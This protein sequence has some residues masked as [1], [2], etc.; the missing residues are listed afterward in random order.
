M[1]FSFCLRNSVK[2]PISFKPALLTRFFIGLFFLLS[3]FLLSAQKPAGTLHLKN[4]D[5]I[6]QENIS[7]E[8]VRNEIKKGWWKKEGYFILV[9]NTVPSASQLNRLAANGIK[10]HH[11]LPDYAYQVSCNFFPSA[12]VLKDAGVKSVV[13]LP[14]EYKFGKEL[15]LFLKQPLPPASTIKV[16]LQ[17][18][19]NVNTAEALT[20]LRQNGFFLTSDQFMN[21]GLLIGT[22]SKNKISEVASLP[23]VNYI[24][25]ANFN[26]QQLNHRERGVYGLTA[27]SSNHGVSRQ[28]N[29][30]GV[31]AG[32][33]D[34]ADPSSHLD[35]TTNAVNRNPSLISSSTHGTIVSSVVSGDGIIQERLTGV[36]PGSFLISD[37]FDFIVTK[38]LT[39]VTDYGLTVTNNSYFNGLNGCIGNGDYNEL[40]AY[41]DGQ[42]YDNPFLQHIFA[43]GN[44]GNLT[45]TPYPTGFGT[46]K[47]G[48]QTA[49]NVLSVGS[50][51]VV[52]NVI[53]GF[54]SKGPVSDGR[55]KPE[56]L[57][58]GGVV[59]GTNINN[60]YTNSTG[61]SFAS[62]GVTG[63]WALL[64]Q[65]YK[66]L[67]GANPKSA[68][69]KTI[70]CNTAND[71][72]NPGPDYRTGFGFVNPQRA[73]QMLE[74]ARYYTNTVGMSGNHTQ[75]IAVPAGTKQLKVMLY[76]HDREGLPSNMNALENDL[77]LT[78]TDG[79]VYQPWV[80]NPA[81]SF[82]TANAIRGADHLN[83]IEQVTIDNP[84]TSVTVNVNGF[85][86]TGTQEFFITYEFIQPELEI[87]Y[88]YGGEHFSSF[89]SSARQEMISWE[90]NDVSTDT[91]RLEY[92]LDDGSNW[93]LIV[94]GI[95]STDFRYLW[96]VPAVN[97]SRAKVRIRRT[98]GSVYSTTPGN[99]VIADQPVV[100][101]TVPCEGYVDL[102]W[103][104]VA[105]ATDYQV[106][107]LINGTLTSV[108]TT[109]SITH[110]ISGLDRNT[111]YWFSI[112]PRLTDSVSR[113]ADARSI[114]PRS[115]TFCTDNFFD[116]DLKIDTLLSS[117][118][119]RIFTSTQLSAT[120]P[121]TVRIKNLD[122]AAS[123]TTYTIS[124]QVNGGAVVNENPGISIAAGGTLDYTFSS[125]YDFSAPGIY[126][127]R[128]FV[129][130]I[131]DLRTENDEVVYT[132]RH[133]NNAPVAL[134][135]LD[136]FESTGD[137]TYRTNSIGL[138]NAERFDYE[139]SSTNGRL[140]TFVNSSMQING[141]R[142]V[143]L[144]VAQFTGF[145]NTNNLFGTYNMT[146]HVATPGLRLD[147]KYRNQGQLNLTETGVW[148]RGQDNQPWV[149]VYNLSSNQG[150][151]GEIKQVSINIDDVMAA[152]GQSVSS[153]FQVRFDQTGNASS[154]NGTYLAEGS[155]IDDG[156][157]FDDIRIAAAVNDL[158]VTQLVS[159]T[160]FNCEAGASSSITVRVRNT[161]STTFNNVP[162]FYRIDNGV[163]VAG[164]IPVIAGNSTVD[165]TFT[166]LADLSQYRTFEIDA[167]T[168]LASDNYP[169]NDTVKN[170]FIYNS[171]VVNSYPYLQRF[172]A[173]DGNFF[174]TGSYSSW[175][176]G[177]TDPLTRTRLRR[178]ANGSNAWFT[179]LSGTYKSNENSYLYSPCFDLSSL[180]NPVLSFAHIS[181]QED[182][183]DFHTVEYTDN[184]GASWQRL[185][186][187]NG[188]TN[189]FTSPSNYWLTTLQRWHVSSVAIPTNASS[190]RFRF[191]MYSDVLVQREGIGIDDI[192]ISEAETIYSGADITGLTQNI[193]GGNNWIPFTSGGNIIAAVNPLGQNLGNTTVSVY[194]N[195]GPV[196][197]SNNQYYLDRNIV[198][199]PANALSDSV[200]VRFYFTEQEVVTMINATN[201]GTCTNITDAFIAGITKFTGSL[202]SME[203]G[204][205]WDNTSGSYAFLTP[206]DVDVIPYNNGYYA[207]FKVRSFSEFWINSGGTNLSTP[208]P[209][210][211]MDFTGAKRATHVDLKWKTQ[212][213]SNSSHFELER[214]ID[215]NST[216]EKIKQVNAAGTSA[217]PI[218]YSYTDEDA[219]TKGKRLQYR[220]KMVDLDGKYTYSEI[221][222]L[223]STSENL[224]IE[225]VYNNRGTILQIVAGNKTGIREIM[226][227]ITNAAGQTQLQQQSS[228]S[229][230]SI[231]ISRLAAGIYFIEIKSRNGDV[232]LQ[233]FIKQ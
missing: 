113:R 130:Q 109:N 66:Q 150:E 161:S 159:P 174:T 180:T 72:G 183:F 129:K 88:P 187:Q 145:S 63:I 81:P 192:H 71:L 14:A 140:R 51:N 69:I 16:S 92:S 149:L 73:V 24:N 48:Y 154:N 7:E 89:A 214:R 195:T 209:V 4:G 120:H 13:Q 184:N 168:A 233:K 44:D 158:T 132:V 84:G 208:L 122:D 126:T 153:S 80:L 83:N 32:V 171:P 54:S 112:R 216:F 67:H 9:F 228:Y 156:F 59:E 115:S 22:L 210:T 1:N 128:V 200:A 21:R 28:L 231:D 175:K 19:P 206:G 98:S 70:L 142:S 224:F 55:I 222:T 86:V 95:A 163:A 173:N 201:C 143:Y 10:F 62:P 203:N 147:F 188:G 211:L 111:T 35:N 94:D 75:A 23:F 135:H 117:I 61:T 8:G 127:L 64:T 189:W 90:A 125:L 20:L 134:P 185:G 87:R 179:S 197:N 100:T 101:A 15:D 212:S 194:F 121:V 221:I 229:N 177:Q 85:N 45:C 220:L 29:G 133:I 225:N 151:L 170:Q 227:R 5:V 139:N 3:T 217:Q 138:S 118:T 18:M 47:S 12:L 196:R 136:N 25:Q 169:E 148:M 181:H 116:N 165:Y 82:V 114:L 215:D 198:I 96:S 78:V 218:Y 164:S 27:L 6:I 31:T 2:K 119:G 207:E 36:A 202:A 11:Y 46:V 178:A 41:I 232:F 204:N 155:D 146:S 157:S 107:Q 110:R 226:I 105:G 43:V 58:S 124:Y 56:I 104:A 160:V 123:S 167:W 152:A 17:L 199:K 230:K 141:N 166:T 30:N 162:V 191:L 223:Q 219:L 205:L 57:A 77:D 79:S 144:D 190:V 33:G 99:F 38:S 93:T 91:Y 65:R 103:A 176:W 26:P 186:V 193:N 50:F 137:D 106:M 172:E 34:N 131:N 68:L 102:S 97:S 74:Q 60:A 37:F 39:Y 52:V 213:E 49:K 108:A 182:Y 76:W 40:S 53:S 42:I